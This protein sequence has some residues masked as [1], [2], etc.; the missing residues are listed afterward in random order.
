MV[1]SEVVQCTTTN[2]LLRVRFTSGREKQYLLQSVAKIKSNLRNRK[3]K[4]G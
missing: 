1:A 4:L 3:L 2:G